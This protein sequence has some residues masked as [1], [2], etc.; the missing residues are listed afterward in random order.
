MVI[1]RG[2]LLERALSHRMADSSLMSVSSINRVLR[3]LAAQKEQQVTA[4]NESVYDKLR[5]FNGQAP[6][7]AWYPGTPPTPHLSLPPNPAAATVLPGG[8]VTRDD[9]QKRVTCIMKIKLSGITPCKVDLNN[10]EGKIVPG[11]GIASVRVVTNQFKYYQYLCRAVASRSK[12]SRLGLALRNARWLESSWGKKFSHEIS[13]SVWDRCPPSIVMH[14]GSYDSWR[15]LRKNCTQVL[16]PKGNQT[17][18]PMQPPMKFESRYLLSYAGS[19]LKKKSPGRN[20]I[21][22]RLSEATIFAYTFDISSM[23]YRNKVYSSVFIAIIT[24]VFIAIITSVFIA[25]IT[26]VFIAIITSVY[27]AVVTSVYIP[28]PVSSLPLLPVSSL[29]LSV[30]SFSLL[31]VS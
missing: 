24:S 3:N 18:I 16:S 4:Q 7:W 21:A 9:I 14:L 31:P 29:L 27:I 2:S 25:I 20:S 15:K 28:S 11:P 8:Q 19:T 13:A 1:D 22:L 26:S 30:S 23:M 17:H 6:G 10:F 5:M 12:A